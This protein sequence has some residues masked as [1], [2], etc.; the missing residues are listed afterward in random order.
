MNTVWILTIIGCLAYLQ[1]CHAELKLLQAVFRHA[2]RMPTNG[3]KTYPNDPYDDLT[4]EPEGYGGLTNVG[5]MSSFKLG[6]YFRERYNEFLGPVY[7]KETIWFRADEIERIVMTGE[8]VA[9]GMYPP[10]KEQMWN[11]HLNW[12]PIPVWAPPMATDYLYNGLNCANFWQ[13]RADVEKNDCG[14]A[15]F[16]SEN[17][18][19]YKYLSEHTG[20][21][22]TQSRVFSLRQLLYAQRDI[23]LEL[24]EWTKE[25]FPGKLDDLA[26]YDILIR[27]RTPKMKQL[28]GGVWIKEWLNR[29]NDYL[30][31][32][33]NR[34]AFMYASHE[35]NL[36]AILVALDNFDYKVPSYSST[37][38]FE[39]HEKN[40]QH[41][42]Q[43]LYRNE[44]KIKTLKIPGCGT[45]LC[46]LE[47]FKKFV[48]PVLPENVEELC[49]NSD[50]SE[51]AVKQQSNY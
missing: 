4:Y 41:F 15:K 49:G 5:K 12:Q 23:G 31:R 21:N 25:V 22:I 14:V 36:A 3:R 48:A 24:P 19:V 34:K 9:A 16:E 2:N 50:E 8:L 30:N 13:W 33:D 42:I 43:I 1:L 20:G 37:I 32:N 46:P 17:K 6:E 40:N 35:L 38:M 10:S 51:S 26:V 44:G 29:V 11:P 27:N 39:L 47:T 28:L 18:D 45:D 7:T